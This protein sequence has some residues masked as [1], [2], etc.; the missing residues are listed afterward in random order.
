LCQLATLPRMTFASDTTLSRPEPGIINDPYHVHNLVYE[1]P[2]W[3]DPFD[4]NKSV[5][6]LAS[7]WKPSDHNKAFRVT[8]IHNARLR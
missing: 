7:S 1:S 5:P 2:L 8:L 6:G 4:A 3:F